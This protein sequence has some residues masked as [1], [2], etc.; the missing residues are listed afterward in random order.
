[1]FYV[2]FRLPQR[3][4]TPKAGNTRLHQGNLGL[5]VGTNFCGG[6]TIV[7]DAWGGL[8]GCVL[9]FVEG[10]GEG[11]EVVGTVCFMS[12]REEVSFPRFDFSILIGFM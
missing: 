9:Y 11:T 8:F 10:G 6:H 5:N 12:L 2:P 1:M 7:G 3:G 4:P